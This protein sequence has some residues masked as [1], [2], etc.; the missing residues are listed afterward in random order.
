ME[1]SRYQLQAMA[2]KGIVSTIE[3][4]DD[5]GAGGS[6]ANTTGGESPYP[7]C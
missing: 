5:L 2:R 4:P 7:S 1:I 3:E 6:D